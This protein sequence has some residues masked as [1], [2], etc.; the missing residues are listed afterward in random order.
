M[1]TKYDIIVDYIKDKWLF[2][3]LLIILGGIIAIPQIRDGVRIL[4][5]WS[6]LFLN[7][8]KLS[9]T[10][11]IKYKNETILMKR[12]YTNSL[13]DVVKIETNSHSLGIDAEHK[14][15]KKYYP[16]FENHMQ[17]LCFIQTDQGEKVFDILPITLN[18]INKDI[19]FDITSFFYEPIGKVGY[20][21]KYVERKRQTLYKSEKKI[22]K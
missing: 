19:Y 13:F 10:F 6:K 18:N 20:N 3:I 1:N 2:A 4:L 17:S 12:T 21:N 7:K 5:E 11:K 14:W 16:G 22:D 9:N 8:W 15:L